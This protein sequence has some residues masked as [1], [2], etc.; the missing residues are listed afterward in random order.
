MQGSH[1]IQVK[2]TSA[3]RNLLGT[4]WA[5]LDLPEGFSFQKSKDVLTLN[6]A[7]KFSTESILPFEIDQTKVNDAALILYDSPLTLDNRNVGIDRK[8][9]V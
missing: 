8:S 5:T 4:E 3:G 9:V 2:L 7:N 1:Q 6:T